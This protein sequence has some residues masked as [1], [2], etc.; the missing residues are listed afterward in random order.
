MVAITAGQR[1]P[2]L[3]QGVGGTVPCPHA[4]PPD[5][6]RGQTALGESANGGVGV[7]M[8]KKPGYFAIARGGHSG[9]LRGACSR[10]LYCVYLL[11]LFFVSFLWRSTATGL[12]HGELVFPPTVLS[13][14]HCTRLAPSSWA[15][16]DTVPVL[17]L[18]L[19]PPWRSWCRCASTL[20]TVH[21]WWKCSHSDAQ[22]PLLRGA[23]RGGG[24]PPPLRLPPQSLLI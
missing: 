10:S 4:P 13:G 11:F 12:R 18:P 22:P 14:L 9:R 16:T 15:D 6:G 19:T 1:R 5:V 24:V 17:I 7:R 20:P 3:V 2:R 21:G 8:A 23:L